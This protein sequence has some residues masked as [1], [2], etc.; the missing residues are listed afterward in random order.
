VTVR[1]EDLERLYSEH[2]RPLYRF[3]AYQT[4]DFSTAEDLLADTFERVLRS[5]RRFDPRRA[6]EKTW[7]YTIAMNLVRDH[8]RRQ[9]AETRALDRVGAGSGNEA[10]DVTLDRVDQRTAVIRA[11]QRLAPEEREAVAL[12]YGADLTLEA[13]A[14]VLGQPRTTVESRVY[15]ALRRLKVEL[16]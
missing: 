9:G 2:S 1:A 6:T 4:G 12:R 16:E 13:T 11:V 5:H 3:L 15:R 14:A 7:L 8:R 10:D